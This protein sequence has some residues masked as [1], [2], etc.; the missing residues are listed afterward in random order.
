VVCKHAKAVEE[1]S[2]AANGRSTVTPSTMARLLVLAGLVFLI[3][4]RSCTGKQPCDSIPTLEEEDRQ[5]GAARPGSVV[6]K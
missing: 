5:P 4:V 1:E 2:T 3:G 6:P